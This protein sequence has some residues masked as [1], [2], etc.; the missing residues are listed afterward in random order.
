M[1]KTVTLSLC[2]SVYSQPIGG[3][4]YVTNWQY[5]KAYRAG[6]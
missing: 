3:K 6:L 2:V 5:L 4:S 1:Q